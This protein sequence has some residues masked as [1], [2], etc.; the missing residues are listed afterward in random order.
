MRD[1]D[2]RIH[3]NSDDVGVFLLLSF[4][5]ISGHGV[6][7]SDVVHYAVSRTDYEC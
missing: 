1:T 7:F 4:S 5:E 3:V 6:R 2:R